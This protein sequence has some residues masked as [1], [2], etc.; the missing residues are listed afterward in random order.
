MHLV[1]LL[2]SDDGKRND[3]S[4]L[5]GT[6]SPLKEGPTG[7]ENLGANSLEI[8]KEEAARGSNYVSWGLNA[9]LQQKLWTD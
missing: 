9:S 4:G 6:S 1:D 7:G 2:F 8:S 3:G 5:Q